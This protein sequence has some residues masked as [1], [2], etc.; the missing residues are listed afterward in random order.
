[1]SN[2][3]PEFAPLFGFIF[4]PSTTHVFEVVAPTLGLSSRPSHNHEFDEVAPFLGLISL[5]SNSQVL[6]DVAPVLGFSSLPSHTQALES[7][8]SLDI[9]FPLRTNIL[10]QRASADKTQ[11]GWHNEADHDRRGT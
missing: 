6:L 10:A 1:M 2:V 5:P 9:N 11:R 8:I 7:L 3:L 4:L